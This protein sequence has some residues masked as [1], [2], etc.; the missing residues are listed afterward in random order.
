MV[1]V[2]A[3]VKNGRCDGIDELTSV[4]CV[5]EEENCRC[6][7]GCFR[8]K[9]AYLIWYS[10]INM[11]VWIADPRRTAWKPYEGVSL[12]AGWLIG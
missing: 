12:V 3:A 6:L 5:R 7:T 4:C 2:D 8:Q 1:E 11:D 10:L 9:M